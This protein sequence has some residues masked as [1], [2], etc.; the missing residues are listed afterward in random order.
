MFPLIGLL[1]IGCLLEKRPGALR[2]SLLLAG[3]TAATLVNPY[4]WKLHAHILDYLLADW[5]VKFVTEAQS[6]K[7]HSEAMV[8]FLMLLFTGLASPD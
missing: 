5:V 7:F 1:V 2:Y 3:T 4:G 6:P 8:F